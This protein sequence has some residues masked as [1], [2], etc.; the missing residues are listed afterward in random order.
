MDAFKRAVAEGRADDVLQAAEAMF[1][2]LLERSMSPVDLY[3]L[4]GYI[5]ADLLETGKML[6]CMCEFQ[7]R[8]VDAGRKDVID[9]FVDLD[10]TA[11][12]IAD[13]IG[14]KGKYG[15]K[16]LGITP[17]PAAARPLFPF[18]SFVPLPYLCEPCCTPCA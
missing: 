12:D 15:R 2:R 14:F 13:R 7:D 8:F 3:I 5:V 4:R 11:T 17:H 18:R 10:M 6:E 16:G 9:A 1:R